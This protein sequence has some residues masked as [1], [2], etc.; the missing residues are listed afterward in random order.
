MR[1]E[2]YGWVLSHLMASNQ[3]MGGL[4]ASVRGLSERVDQ[5]SRR[6]DKVEKRRETPQWISLLPWGQIIGAAMLVAAGTVLHLTTDEWKELVLN[7][8][9][10]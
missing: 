2:P 9:G 6:L 4:T 3:A 7:R 10:K 5:L 8:L 1:G